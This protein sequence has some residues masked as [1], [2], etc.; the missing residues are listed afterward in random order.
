MILMRPRVLAEGAQ[1]PTSSGGD[2]ALVDA[3]GLD[4]PHQLLRSLI[5]PTVLA[6]HFGANRAGATQV[7]GLACTPVTKRQSPTGQA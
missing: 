6:G 3:G 5:Q 2:Q 1:G 4:D 7:S